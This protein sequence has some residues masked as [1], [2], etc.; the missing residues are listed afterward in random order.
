MS[1]IKFH[2]NGTEIIVLE[3]ESTYK[4][5]LI[6]CKNLDSEL[7]NL[8][9]VS[10]SKFFK[11]FQ[12]HTPKSL[13]DFFRV[14]SLKYNLTQNN[15]FGLIRNEVKAKNVNKLVYEICSDSDY[16]NN[17]FPSICQSSTFENELT[18]AITN[19]TL[20]TEENSNDLSSG[21]IVGIVVAVFVG[22]LFL[23]VI[24]TRC[25]NRRP[26]KTT[27]SDLQID[28]TRKILKLQYKKVRLF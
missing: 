20:S 7:I 21:S 6:I 25:K 28:A 24:F 8:R 14:K 17:T 19:N 10:I 22:V 3:E 11:K 9:N 23:L 2:Y 13:S 26:R 5:S 12:E 16:F 27:L 18:T 15:C 4:D 1:G